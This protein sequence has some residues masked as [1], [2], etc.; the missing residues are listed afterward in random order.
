[1]FHFVKAGDALDI[2]FD[3]K[4]VATV[5]GMDEEATAVEWLKVVQ[6][7][8]SF[9]FDLKAIYNEPDPMDDFSFAVEE[10]SVG[11]D[12]L[13]SGDILGLLAGAAETLSAFGSAE[14]DAAAA[15]LAAAQGHGANAVAMAIPETDYI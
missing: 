3:D 5:H 9:Q 14:S 7:A 2:Q 10:V 6:G 1:A 4:T 12:T 8:D 11:T 15:D 13:A